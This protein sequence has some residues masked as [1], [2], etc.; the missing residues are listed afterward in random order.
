MSNY[1]LAIGL[2][3]A[4]VLHCAWREYTNDNRRDAKLLAAFG[5]GGLLT[6]A[7]WLV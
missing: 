2:I 7:A 6:A 3:A 5:A 4:I 1:A